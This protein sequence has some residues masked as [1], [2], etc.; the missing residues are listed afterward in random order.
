MLCNAE[1]RRLRMMKLTLLCQIQ[2]CDCNICV[3]NSNLF[4]SLLVFRV[5]TDYSKTM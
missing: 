3:V 2:L 4:I 1:I 5:K